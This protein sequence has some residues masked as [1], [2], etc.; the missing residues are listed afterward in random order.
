M[1]R[2][3]DLLSKSYGVKDIMPGDQ[4]VL[5]IF[6]RIRHGPIFELDAVRA[7]LRLD[8]AVTLVNTLPKYKVVE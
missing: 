6:P 2:G 4:R 3:Y 1:T 8:E 5:L 7:K